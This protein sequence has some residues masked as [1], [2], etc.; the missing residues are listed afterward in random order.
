M[1]KEVNLK[2]HVPLTEI[3][4]GRWNLGGLC[5]LVPTA[6]KWYFWMQKFYANENDTDKEKICGATLYKKL[7]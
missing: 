6:K 2:K 3:Y 1:P 7:K 4:D 5:M